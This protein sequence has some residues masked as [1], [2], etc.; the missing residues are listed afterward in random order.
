MRLEDIFRISK[1]TKVI[2]AITFTVSLLAVLFAYF[3][4]RSLNRSEDPRIEVARKLL[5]DYDIVAGSINGIEAFP[6][7]DSAAAIFRSIPDYTCSFEIGVIYN[8]KCSS[9][10]LMAMY[11]STINSAVKNSLL[12]LSLAYSDS[13][14]SCYRKWEAEWGLLSTDDIA[15]KLSPVMKSDDPAFRKLDFEKVFNR[16]IKNIV[17]AQLEIDRR[18]SVSLT[19]RG[20]IYR[21]LQKPDSALICYNNALKLW[22]DNRTARSNMSVLMGGK[23]V[24]PS[25]IESLFP[26]DK[27]KR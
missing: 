27:N 6:A 20:T 7:L 10:L 21:H 22:K 2:F 8:N 23:P 13:S 26:P 17:K 14:I 24:T 4:Y 16:R 11:D 19:N 9:L 15:A 5:I 12:D 3:Y 25:L 1:G 18:I